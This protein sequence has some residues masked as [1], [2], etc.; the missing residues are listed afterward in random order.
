MIAPD[1]PLGLPLARRGG[2]DRSGQEEG[3]EIREP[4][5]VEEWPFGTGGERGD[6]VPSKGGIA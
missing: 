3:R 5:A 1:G 4:D 2:G 6:G